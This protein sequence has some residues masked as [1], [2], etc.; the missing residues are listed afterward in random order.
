MKAVFRFLKEIL[1][2][3][4]LEEIKPSGWRFLKDFQFGNLQIQFLKRLN[5]FY[6]ARVWRFDFNRSPMSSQKRLCT[7]NDC[8]QVLTSWFWSTL[9]LLLEC[10]KYNFNYVA[11]ERTVWFHS[12]SSHW[13]YSQTAISWLCRSTRTYATGMSQD[14]KRFG[15]W[16]YLQVDIEF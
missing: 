4:Q 12:K 15:R 6:K 2:N 11:G 1:N 5:K 9:T 16:R 10:L 14:I 8:V 7:T 3:L 13:R